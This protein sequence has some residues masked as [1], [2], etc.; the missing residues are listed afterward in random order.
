MDN[1]NKC[2]PEEA[3][4]AYFTGHYPYMVQAFAIASMKVPAWRLAS[5]GTPVQMF[6][7]LRFAQKWDDEHPRKEGDRSFF[8]VSL[9]GAIGYSD[10]GLEY[11]IQWIFIPMED[12]EERNKLI[13]QTVKEF[14][15]AEKE[16]E[17]AKGE[18]SAT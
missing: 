9:E 13:K 8:Y 16:E 11:H 5:D 15:E 3:K 1:K 10:T 17:A 2:T 12:C 14:E 7:V 18:A 4:K 6:D